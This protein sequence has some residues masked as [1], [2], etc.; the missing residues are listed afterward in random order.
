MM[1]VNNKE[2]S[3]Q[4]TEYPMVPL[5]NGLM[6]LAKFY[7]NEWRPLT[8]VN[9]TAANKKV[10]ALGPGWVVWKGI[11]RPWYVTQGDRKN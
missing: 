8:Y 2:T 5:R 7:K 3:M 10:A 1:I 4:N 11:G 6:V 9:P